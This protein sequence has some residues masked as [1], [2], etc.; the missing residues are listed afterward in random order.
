MS[1]ATLR[2]ILPPEHYQDATANPQWSLPTTEYR[3]T[4]TEVDFRQRAIWCELREDAPAWFTREMLEEL[5]MLQHR[6]RISQET[7]SGVS[8]VET[9]FQ[10]LCSARPGVF[11]Y[12]GDLRLF[13]SL[14]RRRDRNGLA[15]YAKLAAEVVCESANSRQNGITTIAVVE[16]TAFGGGVEAALAADFV[17]AERGVDFGFPE[18]RFNLFPG[19]G[20][21]Q[22]LSRRIPKPRAEEIIL[23]G[24][25]YKAEELHELGVI[26]VLVEPGEARQAA[27]DYRGGPH[28]LDRDFD[29]ISE[30]F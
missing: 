16:G 1:A 4:R 11:S 20:A 17:I 22:L 26:D 29:L 5:R 25:V 10:V 18:I 2:E 23:S 24:S 30:I 19:M 13:A 3:Y 12:G 14:I 28:R 21:Y 8:E 15:A 9:R 6:V 7:E 27:M